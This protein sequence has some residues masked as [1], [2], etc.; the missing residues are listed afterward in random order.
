MSVAVVD[1]AAVV[2]ALCGYPAAAGAVEAMREASELLTCAHL[3]AEVFGA[4][5]RIQRAGDL[6]DIAP[7]L[8]TLSRLGIRRMPL[9]PLLPLAHGLLD[10]VSAQDAL[11][12][13][14][15]RTVDGRL[16]TTDARLRRAVRGILRTG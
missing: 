13:A 11:Y 8:E 6:D 12:V 9:P 15:A 5:A 3:D 14:L 7:H 1:A 16:I 2:D 4:L 10:R